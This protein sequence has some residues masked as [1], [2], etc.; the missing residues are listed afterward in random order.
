MNEFELEINKRNAVG[1]LELA[2]PIYKI[3]CHYFISNAFHELTRI[4]HRTLRWNRCQRFSNKM[5]ALSNMRKSMCWIKD[6]RFKCYEWVWIKFYV[7]HI[8]YIMRNISSESGAHTCGTS[9]PEFCN[10]ILQCEYCL[11]LALYRQHMLWWFNFM[12]I[13]FTQ[14]PN[15]TIMIDLRLRDDRFHFAMLYEIIVSQTSRWSWFM[16]SFLFGVYYS[17]RVQLIN[18]FVCFFRGIFTEFRSEEKSNII[19]SRLR[20]KTIRSTICLLYPWIFEKKKICFLS[21]T[22]FWFTSSSQSLLN[23]TFY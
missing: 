17:H 9:T 1:T 5:R 6:F 19:D 12:Q 21:E 4:I 20:K 16:F 14:P 11:F 18:G 2:K 13:C 7:I 3:C 22:I 23:V 10:I 8:L 15:K